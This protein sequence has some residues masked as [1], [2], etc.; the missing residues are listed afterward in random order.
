MHAVAVALSALAVCALVLRTFQRAA[1]SQRVV[2]SDVPTARRF[3]YQS[4]PT[5]IV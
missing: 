2:L 4:L 3:S 1:R 5:T